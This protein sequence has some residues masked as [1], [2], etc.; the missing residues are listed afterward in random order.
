MI[1]TIS[2]CV[3]SSFEFFARVTSNSQINFDN[4]VIKPMSHQVDFG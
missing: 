4:K 2:V 3:H 1:D